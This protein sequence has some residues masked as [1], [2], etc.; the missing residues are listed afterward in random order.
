LPHLAT[1]PALE[2]WVARRITAY[3]AEQ[4]APG[5]EVEVLPPAA[6]LQ[7]VEDGE[8]ALIVAGVEMPGDWFASSVGFE[9]I[10]VLVHPDNIVRSY[11]LSELASIFAGRLG[12]WDELGG[13]GGEIM[14]LIPLSGDEVR[15]RFEVVVMDGAPSTSNAIIAPSPQAMIAM[16]A[17]NP[18][19]IGY[20]PLSMTSDDVRIVRVD[21][22]LPGPSSLADGTYPLTIEVI[23]AAP[24]EPT[25]VIR[26]WLV[27]LQS[28]HSQDELSED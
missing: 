8:V 12:T 10:A 15:E 3:N 13:S 18:N 1:T 5:F 11:T 2:P 23:A 6:A 19:S 26:D 16:I 20:V 28:D 21:G 22:A 27:W 4:G 25:G 9:G 7:A 24:S 17:A 14:P